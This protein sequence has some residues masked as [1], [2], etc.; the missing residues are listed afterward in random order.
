T[1]A[2]AL[3]GPQKGSYYG[4]VSWGWTM[5]SAGK[6]RQQDLKLASKGDPTSRLLD[7]AK[8]WNKFELPAK[9]EPTGK[10]NEF[11][12]KEPLVVSGKFGALTLAVGSLLTQ[13]GSAA[14]DRIKVSIGPS[15]SLSH[16]QTVVTNIPKDNVDP[17]T[18]TVK[19]D[20]SADISGTGLS[21]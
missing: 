2:L 14:G 3:E 19:K 16:S 13:T 18:M 9:V 8:A 15:V 11:R 10:P 17:K 20:T 5:D 21:V 12:V 1:T 4:S 7:A 6:Y